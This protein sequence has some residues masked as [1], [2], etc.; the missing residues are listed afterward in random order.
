LTAID[1]IKNNIDIVDIVSET[2]K[3][4][5]TGKNYIGFCPF[6][7]NTHTPAFVVFPDSGTW[8]CFGQCAEGGDVFSY[9]MKRDGV[10]FQQALQTL[11]KR[12]GIQLESFASEDKTKKDSQKHLIQ[13]MEDAVSFYMNNLL[14]HPAGKPALAYL[15]KRGMTHETIETF[16]LGYASESWDGTLQNMLS[17]G[18]T[19]EE[20]IEVGLVSEQRDDKGEVIKDG[21]IYDR[22]R[23]RIM[24]PIFDSLGN[25]IAFGARILNPDDVPKFLNSPQT[26]LFDKGKTLFG[27]NQAKRSIREKNQAVIVE[28]YLDVIILHQAGFTNTVSPM[29]TALGE[30]QVKQLARQSRQIILAL[31]ADAAG[32]NAT[33]KGIEVMR[34]ALKGTGE[35]AITESR[36][37]IRQENKLNSDIRITRIPEGMDPDEVVLR[38][39]AEWQQILNDAKPIVTYMMESLGEG[40]NLDDAKVKSE[41]ADQILPLIFEVPEAIERETYRQQLAR[42]LKISENLLRYSPAVKAQTKTGIKTRAAF[43]EKPSLNS[44]SALIFDPKEG[45]YSKEITIMQYLFHFYESPGSFSKIDRVFREF[46]LKPLQKEDFEQIDLREIAACYFQGISQDEELNTQKFIR[47]NIPDSVKATFESIEKPNFRG[48][49]NLT[50]L[51]KDVTRSIAFLR[52]EKC[53]FN[54]NE[55]Q[56]LCLAGVEFEKDVSEY[57]SIKDQLI[58][59]RNFLEKLMESLSPPKKK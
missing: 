29:G 49:V 12:A 39:P 13:L 31:D 54:I 45:F 44:D 14:H 16:K 2:V 48:D 24:I 42:Y 3:L 43:P 32:D 10:D 21:R 50:E 11:A 20:L 26:I 5:R 53:N 56:T 40:K 19:R 28:G 17:K 46:H 52:N 23:N 33:L 34:T 1:E 35:T 6:H 15:E 36:N 18:Y 30:F 25:P 7:S 47:E 37:L 41:I 22:F 4:R 51:D 55:L 27:L 38:N 57:N 58:R 59:E 8:K 9:I